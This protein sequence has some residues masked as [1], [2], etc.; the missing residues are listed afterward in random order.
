M[1]QKRLVEIYQ[2]WDNGTI[3]DVDFD[4]LM[5]YVNQ[6]REV[7]K[8]IHKSIKETSTETASIDTL[9][10]INKMNAILK[11]VIAPVEK[12]NVVNFAIKR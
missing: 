10:L 2:K 9:E 1:N 7:I 6:M 11:K 12:Y 8:D 5:I 3:S 4:Q